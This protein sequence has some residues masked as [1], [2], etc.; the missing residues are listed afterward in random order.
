MRTRFGTSLPEIP[1]LSFSQGVNGREGLEITSEAIET[2]L[3]CLAEAFEGILT[4][5]LSNMDE[6]GHQEWADCRQSADYVSS[7]HTQPH[8]YFPVPQTGKCITLVRFMAAD[9]SFLKSLIAIPRR[10]CSLGLALTRIADEK[11]GVY[12]QAKG[13]TSH[14]HQL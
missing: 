13:C 7:S 5:F 11:A 8:A 10:K 14:L 1:A 2:S 3:R 9:R 12:S 4:H 6:T